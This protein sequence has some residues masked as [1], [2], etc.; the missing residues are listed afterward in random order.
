LQKFNRAKLVL[1]VESRVHAPARSPAVRIFILADVD[2]GALV[3]A[4]AWVG[5][6]KTTAT[7]KILTN[8]IVHLFLLS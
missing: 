5:E 6:A 4:A 3:G 2:V 8:R 7:L 1:L